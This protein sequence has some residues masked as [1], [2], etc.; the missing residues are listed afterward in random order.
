MKKME[1][2]SNSRGNMRNSWNREAGPIIMQDGKVVSRGPSVS[3]RDEAVPPSAIADQ[4]AY[5]TKISKGLYSGLLREDEEYCRFCDEVLGRLIQEKSM[6]L[7]REV[8]RS[9]EAKIAEKLKRM[10][11]AIQAEPNPVSL[12]SDR[13]LDGA[14]AIDLDDSLTD[15][16]KD[17]ALDELFEEDQHTFDSTGKGCRSLFMSLTKKMAE[18]GIDVRG[19]MKSRRGSI[20]PVEDEKND[21]K[22]ISEITDLFREKTKEKLQKKVLKEARAK[23]YYTTSKPWMGEPD[24]LWLED[25]EKWLEEMK[26]KAEKK[27]TKKKV[28]KKKVAKI[29]KTKARKKTKKKVVGKK[30]G[31]N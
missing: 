22:I 13:A 25:P 24:K 10:E 20:G 23:G 21:E 28:S 5:I 27:K 4:M 14:I 15:D 16:E 29:G 6:K 3:L 2:T 18:R 31:Q 8:E 19:V 11:T 9:A 12:K 7:Q 1:I 17:K 26:K 30:S